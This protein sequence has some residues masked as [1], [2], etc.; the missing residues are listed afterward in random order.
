M[1]LVEPDFLKDILFLL[2]PINQMLE[3]T[4]LSCSAPILIGFEKIHRETS[5]TK[6]QNALNLTDT[7]FIFSFD[8]NLIS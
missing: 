4:K 5:S 7:L 1:P 8:S 6:P 3:P 2:P